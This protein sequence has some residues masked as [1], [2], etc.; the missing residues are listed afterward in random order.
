[1]EGRW[2]GLLL[3][4][5]QQL[6][7]RREEVLRTGEI[8]VHRALDVALE[9]LQAQ[10]KSA[11][12]LCGPR[13]LLVRKQA[14]LE[15]GEQLELEVVGDAVIV[16]LSAQA[17]RQQASVGIGRRTGCLCQSRLT[18]AARRRSPAPPPPRRPASLEC[19]PDRAIWCSS[20]QLQSRRQRRQLRSCRPRPPRARA[21]LRPPERLCSASSGADPPQQQERSRRRD[22]SSAWTPA[23]AAV[24]PLCGRTDSA[25]RQ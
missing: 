17:S 21:R 6:G 19:R 10:R 24:A 23:V 9:H 13:R 15:P 5:G 8:L 4:R 12:R 22:E 2:R 11:R 20:G 25:S 3:V 1:M 14:L 7:S 16:L 18:R